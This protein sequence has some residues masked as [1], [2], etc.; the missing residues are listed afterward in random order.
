[1]KSKETSNT[2]TS[3][4]D[5][6]FTVISWHFSTGNNHYQTMMIGHTETI[7]FNLKNNIPL[8]ITGIIVE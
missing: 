1:M 3:D 8:D 6:P 7:V 5:K 2:T 4:H